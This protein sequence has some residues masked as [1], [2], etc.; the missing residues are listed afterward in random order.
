MDT[1]KGFPV[2]QNPKI[3]AIKVHYNVNNQYFKY[4]I[5]LNIQKPPNQHKNKSYGLNWI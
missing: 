4:S 5:L 2:K 3:A 1:Q